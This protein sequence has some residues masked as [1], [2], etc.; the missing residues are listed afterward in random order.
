MYVRVENGV[1]VEFPYSLGR[2]SET[3]P[4]VSFPEN[5][6]TATLA[7]HGIMEVHYGPMPSY[8]G[9]TQRVRLNDLPDLVNGSWIIGRTV[10]DM[11]ATQRQNN[12]ARMSASVRKKRDR[13][14]TDSDWT[15]MNDSPLDTTAR[16]SW[17]TYRQELRDVSAQAGFP[18]SVTYPTQPE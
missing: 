7:E 14:L 13:L 12:D 10:Y 4:T 8:D 9:A 18:H 16:T 6:T 5:P 15:Q 3:F 11:D 1:A 17:A 2:L